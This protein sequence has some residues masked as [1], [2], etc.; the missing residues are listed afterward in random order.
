MVAEIFHNLEKTLEPDAGHAA[1]GS[2][3]VDIVSIHAAPF[4]L[5]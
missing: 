3:N 1:V 2:R 4:P 5:N